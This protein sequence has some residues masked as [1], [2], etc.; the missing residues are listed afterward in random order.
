MC[1]IYYVL[2]RI[3]FLN[4]CLS[5]VPRREM[6]NRIL[7]LMNK[8]WKNAELNIFYIFVSVIFS[9]LS[10]QTNMARIALSWIC[11]IW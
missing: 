9:I 10:Y 8:D 4:T 11:V 7:N 5:T 3:N 6:A 2:Y 1:I